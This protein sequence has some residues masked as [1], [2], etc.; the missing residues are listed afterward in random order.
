MALKWKL[1]SKNGVI[2]PKQI[3]YVRRET[4]S[5]N[6]IDYEVLE[7]G[8]TTKATG[9][10]TIAERPQRDQKLNIEIYNRFF[11]YSETIDTTLLQEYQKK[12][13]V[14]AEYL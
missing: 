14:L 9:V 7:K 10:P 1:F 4:V 2:S 6:R 5:L 12:L 11:H 13:R 3:D 8:E